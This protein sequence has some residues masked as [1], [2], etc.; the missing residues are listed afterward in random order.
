M[1]RTVEDWEGGNKLMKTNEHIKNMED[2]ERRKKEKDKV[3][4]QEK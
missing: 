3:E 2:E 4:D 1:A